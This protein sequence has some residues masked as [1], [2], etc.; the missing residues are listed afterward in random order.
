MGFLKNLQT[1]RESLRQAAE[2]EATQYLMERRLR[3]EELQR[4]QLKKNKQQGGGDYT[5]EDE[6]GSGGLEQSSKPG[7]T[8]QIIAR[9]NELH[10]SPKKKKREALRSKVKSEMADALEDGERA[11]QNARTAK[12]NS[13]KSGKK[14]KKTVTIGGVHGETLSGFRNNDPDDGD[15]EGMALL[16]A[17][18]R[19]EL[20]DQC[21]GGAAQR[22]RRAISPSQDQAATSLAA[23]KRRER[24]QRQRLYEQRIKNNRRLAEALKEGRKQLRGATQSMREKSTTQLCRILDALEV[25]GRMGWGGGEGR[26]R[27]G[28]RG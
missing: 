28:G 16:A 21:P 23:A 6:G 22:Q 3:R 1:Q 13:S 19:R 10:N 24:M 15:E 17:S 5:D 7:A 14:K 25:R 26:G 4:E 11:V 9:I 20:E 18:S 27:E 12:T 8:A 2:S